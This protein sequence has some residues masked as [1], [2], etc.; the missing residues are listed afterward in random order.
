MY[1]RKHFSD[2]WIGHGGPQNWP[3]RSPDFTPCVFP[4]LGLHEC[5]VN[6]GDDLHDRIFAAARRLNGPY[7][8][9]KVHI[10]LHLSSS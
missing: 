3:L 10:I 8:L 9:H 5:K 6:R 4:C 7:V 1:L 2:L